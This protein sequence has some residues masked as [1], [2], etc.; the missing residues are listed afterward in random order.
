MAGDRLRGY[1]PDDQAPARSGDGAAG[2]HSVS[3]RVG[4]WWRAT[5]AATLAIILGLGTLAGI[6]ALGQP[7][8]VLVIG[9][10]VASALAPIVDLLDRWLPRAIAIVI[11]YLAFPALLALIGYFTLPP[12]INQLENVT[13][14]IPEFVNQLQPLLNRLGN[15][16]PSDLIGTLTSHLSQF[17]STLVSLPLM[18]VNSLVDL[19]AIIFISIYALLSAEGARQFLLSLVP[20]DRQKKLGDLLHDMVWEM[21]G[22][23]RGAF[24][25]GLIIGLS[26]YVGLLLIGVDFPLVLGLFA[27]IMEIIPAIG[28][29]IAAVPIL[30]VALLQSPT[31]A[32]F[33]LIFMLAIHQFEGNIV[34]PNVMR[35][36]TSISPLLVLLALLSGY[37]AG[38]LLGALTAIPLVAVA[39]VFIIQVIAPAI[40]RETGAPEPKKTGRE[41]KKKKGEKET[42]PENQKE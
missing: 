1:A 19:V 9:L 40:R 38:G 37:A 8:A 36:Q 10:T 7:L 28:P 2:V 23:L 25:D 39:R 17:A 20:A 6:R 31:K 18:I 35:S 29:I 13:S 32:L 3:L 21:G 15:L 34:F 14:R 42:G 11:V 24:L 12:L 33:S 16:A 5:L 26:T 41:E 4:F 30:L 22:Y 27:G